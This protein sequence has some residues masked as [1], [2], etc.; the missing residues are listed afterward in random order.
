VSEAGLRLLCD[1]MLAGLARWLRAA[2]Y[3]TA[4][5]S[6]GQ[7]DAE[8]LAL[9]EAEG[10][11]LITRDRR[12]AHVAAANLRAVLLVGDDLDAHARALADALGV[13]WTLA[14]FTRCVVDN[15]PLRPATAEEVARM[16]AATRARP[17][18]FN[19]CPACGRLY[20]PGS[21][22]KRMDARLRRWRAPARP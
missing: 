6:Q 18:P 5:A 14:P 20:W 21:H 8:L 17:G 3:D 2:G 11:A 22:V 15:A 19:A 4:L 13:D 12:L 1:E 16:P 7:P 10:R 9:A